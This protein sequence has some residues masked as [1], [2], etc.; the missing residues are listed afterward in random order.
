MPS[1]PR[2]T[3][4]LAALLALQT[5]VAGA[6]TSPLDLAGVQADF[7]RPAD[8]ALAPGGRAVAF[9][10]WRSVT[11]GATSEDR[12]TIWVAAT[13]GSWERPLTAPSLS[14]DTPQWSP[15]GASIAYLASSGGVREIWLVAAAGGEP[16][17]LTASP[18]S[19]QDFRWLPDGHAFVYVAVKSSAAESGDAERKSAEARVVD[20][21]FDNARLWRVGVP[22]PGAAPLA[23]VALTPPDRDVVTDIALSFGD[24]LRGFDVSPDGRQIVFT[25]MPTPRV[26]DWKRTDLSIVDLA[27]GAIRTLVASN[28][29][30]GAPHFSPDGR[31]VVFSA[32]DDPPNNSFAARLWVVAAAGGAPRALT[33]TADER[34]TPVGWSADGSEVY[35]VETRGTLTRLSALPVDGE[36]SRDFE[37]G[38]RVLSSIVLDPART[39]FAFVAER[40]DEAP[41]VWTTGVARFD[42]RQ[43]THFE[44]PLP[45]ASLGR[46]ELLRWTAPDGLEIEG[47]LTYPVDYRPGVRYPLLLV[48]HGG[49][50]WYFLQD[51][52]AT[53][54]VYPLATFAAR[55]FAVLRP[56]PRGSSGRGRAFRFANREDWGGGDFQDLMAGVEHVIALGVADSDRLGVM[57]WSYGGYMTDWI[58]SQTGRFKAASSGAGIANLTSFAGTSDILD[59]LPD[60]F[61]GSPWQRP[62]IY[63][64][65]SP[66]FHLAGATTPT[67]IQHGERDRRVPL[68]QSE[69]LYRALR[70]LGVEAELVIYSR[71]PH[72]LEEPKLIVDAARRNLA[73]FERHLLGAAD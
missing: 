21:T 70:R 6:A 38:D 12:G 36:R 59:F 37:S 44:P 11:E 58:I 56:N 52:L 63:L 2:R 61:G 66:L 60:Y 23:G 68:G 40:P 64:A 30:E 41:Q 62:E 69:E 32:S 51:Y 55:G 10:L 9:T 49:P 5:A 18:A 4:L 57:G 13:D 27:T 48:I 71:Q 28:R 43:V 24:M 50:T 1:A 15:D 8:L 20:A 35:F 47:L 14:A 17:R 29:A 73:W 22:P 45:A 65:R 67:L 34:A 19:V 72:G 26:V 7:R 54:D 33:P 25:H 42:A 39:Q 3:G 16:R 53:P 46:T 31:Q